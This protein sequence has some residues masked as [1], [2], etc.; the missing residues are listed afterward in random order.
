MEINLNLRE[1][2]VGLIATLPFAM[3]L[4]AVGAGLYSAHEHAAVTKLEQAGAPAAEIASVEDRANLA[5][6]FALFEGAVAVT[7]AGCFGAVYLAGRG[8]VKLANRPSPDELD[9]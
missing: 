4:V 2:T 3:G 1:H 6:N 7:W 8:T 5:E 9:R